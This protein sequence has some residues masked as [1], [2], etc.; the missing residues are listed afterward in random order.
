MQHAHTH[1]HYYTKNKKTYNFFACIS[2][3]RHLRRVLI[4]FP[5]LLCSLLLLL[6]IWNSMVL[7]VYVCA[8]VCVY[9]CMGVCVCMYMCV[10]V[11]VCMCVCVCMCA[12]VCIWYS[13][14]YYQRDAIP[15]E[16]INMPVRH[17]TVLRCTYTFGPSNNKKIIAQ[18]FHSQNTHIDSLYG[19]YLK[20][21]FHSFTHARAHTHIHTHREVPPN[22]RLRTTNVPAPT[23]VT[24]CLDTCLNSY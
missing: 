9:V 20:A 11:Y 13:M 8:C 4:G 7:C 5:A 12:C 17:H 1:T 19:R 6:C 21:I 24:P 23:D 3:T 18:T 15:F 16:G 14:L 10:C 2:R 22:R